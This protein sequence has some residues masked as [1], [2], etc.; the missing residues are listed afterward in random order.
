M[1]NLLRSLEKNN[2]RFSDEES[3]KIGEVYVK[4]LPIIHK[5]IS[6]FKWKR[7]IQ[8]NTDEIESR[9]IDRFLVAYRNYKPELQDFD[10]YINCQ[11]HFAICGYYDEIIRRRQ[12]C[13]SDCGECGDFDQFAATN[14]ENEIIRGTDLQTA[15]VGDAQIL[16]EFL[17]NRKSMQHR[18]RNTRVFSRRML[19]RGWSVERITNAF[20]DLNKIIKEYCTN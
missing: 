1:R 5:K 17:S 7:G 20:V 16:F 11:L 18:R 13:L 14:K 19:K 15:M 3:T 2:V 12:I 9:C 8:G 4:I 6:Q 10:K